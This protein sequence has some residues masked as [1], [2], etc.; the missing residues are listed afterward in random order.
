[1]YRL[2]VPLYESIDYLK[3]SCLNSFSLSTVNSPETGGR[4][5]DAAD[6]PVTA[7]YKALWNC[8]TLVGLEANG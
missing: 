5:V 3:S 7:E 2:N 6:L 4:T 8:E 1:M